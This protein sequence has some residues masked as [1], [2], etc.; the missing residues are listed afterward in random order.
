MTSYPPLQIF[1]DQDE[2]IGKA[3]LS[4]IH[5][6]GLLHRSILVVVLDP[7]GRL[8]LQRRSANV[9]TNATRWDVSAAG[10]ADPGEDYA[11]AA[12]RELHEEI[13]IRGVELNEVAYYRSNSVVNGHK[14]NR[15]IKI[16]ETVV[17]AHTKITIDK[18]EVS[19]VRWL[20]LDEIMVWLKKKPKEFNHDFEEVLGKI[21]GRLREDHSH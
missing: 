17:P 3:Y 21:K 2:P 7:A 1:N 20:T 9:A 6:K 16:Y 19:A 13:G 10:H 12:A 4:E 18:A 11:E 8:L 14:L 15:F 5:A